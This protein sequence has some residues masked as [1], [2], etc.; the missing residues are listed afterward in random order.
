M[1][2]E[3]KLT[4]QKLRF[5]AGWKIWKNVFF[6]IEPVVNDVGDLPKEKGIPFFEAEL[7]YAEHEKSKWIIDM[8]WIPEDDPSGE[9]RLDV[10]KESF[11]LNDPITICK[12]R[13]KNEL[14]EAINKTMLQ[15]SQESR[16]IPLGCPLLKDLIV[17]GGWKVTHNN[18]FNT[19]HIPESKRL[20]FLG[21]E[22]LR[23]EIGSPAKYVIDLSW[24]PAYDS[25]GCYT[26]S[27]FELQD[28]KN[29][30]YRLETTNI[31]EV[32]TII[33]KLCLWKDPKPKSKSNN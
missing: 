3:S 2:T 10:I 31:N 21:T 7:L 32:P 16:D 11:S 9:F 5:P 8:G 26:A 17:R 6:D 28:T 24:Q 18:F 4:I 14:V 33:E 25:K 12:T 27:I 1:N 19:D 13:D 23:L 29:I 20:A 15:I 22:M 30:L